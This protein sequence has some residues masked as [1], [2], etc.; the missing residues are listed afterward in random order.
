MIS[1]FLLNVVYG[2][3]TTLLAPL[4][5]LS[6]NVDSTAFSYF[7][8]VIQVVSYMLP[9]KTVSVVVTLIFGF[10]VFKIFIAIIKTIWD[11]LPLV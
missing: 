11:L 8:S 4:P 9:M 6:W 2:I 1:E 7:V 3:V 5:D 10:N